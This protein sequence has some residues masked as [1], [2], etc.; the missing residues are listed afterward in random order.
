MVS[1][2]VHAHEPLIK[3]TGIF[4]DLLL[5]PDRLVLRHTD[6][7]SQFFGH[8]EVIALRDIKAVH[9]HPAQF[10]TAGYVQ[11]LING[12]EHKPLGVAFRKGEERKAYDLQAKITELVSSQEVVPILHAMKA[13]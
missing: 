12:R 11:L 7:L 4:N 1:S 13:P 6:I 10:I 2:P 9:I 3:V 5:Y 8:E